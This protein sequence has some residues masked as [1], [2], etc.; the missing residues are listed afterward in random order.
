MRQFDA[1]VPRYR[2][3]GRQIPT[4]SRIDILTTTDVLAHIFDALH[5]GLTDL[6]DRYGRVVRSSILRVRVKISEI[7]PKPPPRV[8]LDPSGKRIR[9]GYRHEVL[10][11]S[12][13]VWTG[14]L[15]PADWPNPNESLIINFRQNY[16]E[17]AHRLLYAPKLF[18]CGPPY[19]AYPDLAV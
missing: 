19:A 10:P 12:L 13:H 5:L 3:A 18:Y 2:E 11:Q 8:F 16:G 14:D 17:D 9:F 15:S 1:A 7:T 4:H 6:K